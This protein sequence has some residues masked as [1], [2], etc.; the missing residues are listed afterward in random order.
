MQGPQSGVA[1]SKAQS[2]FAAIR[3]GRMTREYRI[4]AVATQETTTRAALPTN[5]ADIRPK[6]NIPDAT[7][8]AKSTP[9]PVNPTNRS[10]LFTRSTSLS[11]TS[12]ITK[13][14][15]ERKHRDA[16][17]A[18]TL[19]RG[20]DMLS[21]TVTVFTEINSHS[22]VRHDDRILAQVPGISRLGPSIC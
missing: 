5:A 17:K 12:F 9:R 7:R 6:A 21:P 1:A 18:A 22:G 8:T 2:R 15:E 10:I 16:P 4:K 20:A 13:P 14:N 19:S 11:Q 3:K